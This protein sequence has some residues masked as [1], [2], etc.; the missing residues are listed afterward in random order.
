MESK[1]LRPFALTAGLIAL[2]Q[3]TKALVVAKVPPGWP[4]AF[5]IGGDFFWLI[6]ST[7]RGAAWSMGDGLPEALRI[8]LLIVIPLT[9]LA[10][11][12]VYLVRGSDLTGP[13]RWML[14]TVIGGG[15]GNQIDRIFRPG[16][17]VD[18]ASFKFYGLFG[19][20]RFPSFNVADS[21]I[22]VGAILLVISMAATEARRKKG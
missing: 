10:L 13:Q 8:L 19:M 15:L 22:V 18:F 17:V 3:L 20:E 9:V 16:G 2:D 4:P 14:A 1:R 12:S 11:A 5:T 21:C 6:H 7:N